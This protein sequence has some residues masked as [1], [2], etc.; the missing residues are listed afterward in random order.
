MTKGRR[1]D[2]FQRWIR[3]FH[4]A[5][6]VC[7]QPSPYPCPIRVGQSEQ[8]R[9]AMMSSKRSGFARFNIPHAAGFKLEYR[10]RVAFCEQLIR[11]YIVKWQGG[12]I[13]RFHRRPLC[14]RI[15]IRLHRPIDNSQRTQTEEVEFDQPIASTSS[16]SIASRCFLPFHLYLHVLQT[17]VRISNGEGAITNPRHVCRRCGSSSSFRVRSSRS[18]TSSFGAVALD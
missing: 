5:L 8:S 11:R 13:E 7:G 1:Q 12:D 18:L 3:I 10:D 4:T 6:P 15:L 9:S 2:L 16:L 14:G 17:A